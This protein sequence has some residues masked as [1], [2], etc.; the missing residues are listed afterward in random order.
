MT[1]ERDG[2]DARLEVADDG[3]GIPDEALPHLFD[4]FYRVDGARSGRGNGAGLGLAIVRWIVQQHGGRVDVDAR[5]GEGTRFTVHLPAAP[6]R[7]DP[8]GDGRGPEEA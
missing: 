5:P 6:V 2:D 3:P 8:A 7:D 4:R 1:A